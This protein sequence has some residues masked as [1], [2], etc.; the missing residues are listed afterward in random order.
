MAIALL[1]KLNSFTGE[2]SRKVVEG[3]SIVKH[4]F[5]TDARLELYDQSANHGA[6]RDSA[7]QIVNSQP[8]CLPLLASEIIEKAIPT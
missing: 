5:C 6:W 2:I 1:R 7:L 8:D 3:L 4:C